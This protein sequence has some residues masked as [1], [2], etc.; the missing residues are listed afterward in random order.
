MEDLAHAI[1]GNSALELKDLTLCIPME[2]D[3]YIEF[4]R[5][6]SLGTRGAYNMSPHGKNSSPDGRVKVLPHAFTVAVKGMTF[7]IYVK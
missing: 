2:Y 1:Y 5:T 6:I 3:D 7:L 4:E